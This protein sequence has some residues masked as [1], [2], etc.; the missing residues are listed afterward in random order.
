[1]SMFEDALTEMWWDGWRAH[2]NNCSLK[3]ERLEKYLTNYPLLASAPETA[4][5]RDE[6][7]EMMRKLVRICKTIQCQS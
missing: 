4:A 7:C 5:E 6:L 1:M 2:R 3:N